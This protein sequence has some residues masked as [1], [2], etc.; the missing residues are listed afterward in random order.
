MNIDADVP[1]TPNEMTAD[2]RF[3]CSEFENVAFS[4]LLHFFNEEA[5]I[6][7]IR[8][9]ARIFA[10]R[11][12]SDVDDLQKQS[13]QPRRRRFQGRSHVLDPTRTGKSPNQRTASV[14]VITPG[15]SH[16]TNPATRFWR[17]LTR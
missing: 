15:A 13:P 17:M 2:R 7:V 16:D 1:F 4:D 3:A 11:L 12:T 9:G 5:E 10:K 8:V 14:I 6:D